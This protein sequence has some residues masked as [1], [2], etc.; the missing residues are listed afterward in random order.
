ML[1]FL[2]TKKIKKN[3]KRKSARKIHLLIFHNIIL[4][5]IARVDSWILAENWGQIL[6]I[7][8]DAD[9]QTASLIECYVLRIIPISLGSCLMRLRGGSI[10]Q[11]LWLQ[12]NAYIPVCFLYWL[13][14]SRILF[15]CQQIC[16]FFLFE[17]LCIFDV[18]FWGLSAVIC[19][20]FYFFFD[21][22]VPN[23]ILCQYDW[24]IIGTWY[25]QSK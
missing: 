6:K 14:F 8:M 20:F 18:S 11:T 2:T 10:Y 24:G 4:I 21:F 22:P 7:S 15:S 23:R 13:M 9:I 3:L 12:L 17:D 25:Q 5:Q 1:R 16:K 19:L